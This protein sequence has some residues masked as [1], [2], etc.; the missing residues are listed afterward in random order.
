MNTRYL[1]KHCISHIKR[2]SGTE[3]KLQVCEDYEAAEEAVPRG[4]PLS[5]LD[6]TVI[7]IN[8]KSVIWQQDFVVYYV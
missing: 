4:G 5:G 8:H 2:Y 6:V 7:D 1:I 3:M